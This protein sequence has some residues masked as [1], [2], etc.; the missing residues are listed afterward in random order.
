MSMQICSMRDG[1]DLW[2]DGRGG[3]LRNS[4][5]GGKLREGRTLLR[6]EK[7]YNL[8]YYTQTLQDLKVN[9]N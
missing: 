7:A 1:G 3:G 6:E 9:K 2:L 5:G 4:W 8:D